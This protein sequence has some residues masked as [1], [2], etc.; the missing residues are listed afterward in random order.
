MFGRLDGVD[1]GAPTRPWADDAWLAALV[2]ASADPIVVIDAQGV[3]RYAYVAES[4]ENTADRPPATQLIKAIE[5][6][7]RR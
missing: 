4:L 6:L 2:D 5:N 3:V 1:S 7:R